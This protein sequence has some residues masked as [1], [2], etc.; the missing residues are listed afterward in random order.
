MAKNVYGFRLWDNATSVQVGDFVKVYTD[1]V[2]KV[3][4]VNDE[5]GWPS[6]PDYDCPCY[7]GACEE[8]EVAVEPLFV[9]SYPGIYIR[10]CLQSA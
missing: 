10:E 9:A 4:S 8:V 7:D 1:R 3:L 6:N 5:C 2:F